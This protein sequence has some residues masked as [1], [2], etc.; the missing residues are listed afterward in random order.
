MTAQEAYEEDC[1]RKPNYDDGS[2]RQNWNVLDRVVQSSWV[3][4]P[5][6]RQFKDQ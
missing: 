6:P 1:R 4:N 5:T 2:R 3:K